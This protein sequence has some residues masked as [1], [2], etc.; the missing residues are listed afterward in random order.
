VPISGYDNGMAAI[1]F[2]ILPVLIGVFSGI[3]SGA[4][5]YR[6]LFLEEVGKGLCPH[7]TRQRLNR[8]PN[9]FRHVLQNAMIRF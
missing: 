6:T 1:K 9:L 2:L 7:R 4:R 5:W 3:G 8:N